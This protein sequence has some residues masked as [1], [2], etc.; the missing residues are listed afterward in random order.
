MGMAPIPSGMTDSL[1][2]IGSY[3][4]DQR[5]KAGLSVR[6]LAERAG[7]SNPYISQIERGLRKPSIEVLQ[8]LARGL[9]LSTGSVLGKFGVVDFPA[10]I[11]TADAIRSDEALSAEQKRILLDLYTQFTRDPMQS[12]VAHQ[13]ADTHPPHTSTESVPETGKS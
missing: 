4:R 2:E 10:G 13:L 11:P 7:V 3:L 12:E 6:Q 9:Q 5:E 8:Q 1:G